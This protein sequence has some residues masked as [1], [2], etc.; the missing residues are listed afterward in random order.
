MAIDIN[1]VRY[2][3]CSIERHTLKI[4]NAA[5]DSSVIHLR[6]MIKSLG[7]IFTQRFVSPKYIDTVALCFT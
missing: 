2:F 7:N 6:E 3:Y 4:W 1:F 5:R